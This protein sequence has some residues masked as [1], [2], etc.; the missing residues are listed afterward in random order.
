MTDNKEKP[1]N[2]G[3]SVR[4]GTS[5]TRRITPESKRAIVLRT[6]LSKGSLTCFEAVRE[7]H[8]YVLRS[9]VSDLQREF[10]IRIDR[11]E[12]TVPNA[13]GGRTRCARYWISGDQRAKV[14]ALLGEASQ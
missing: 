10:G 13:F 8:D 14:C 9:T 5:P 11:T 6:L 2:A 7:C 12:I 3:Q 4:H 1:G